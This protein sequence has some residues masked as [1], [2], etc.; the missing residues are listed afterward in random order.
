LFTHVIKSLDKLSL[1]YLHLIEPRSTMAGGTDKVKDDQPSASA[2][3]RPFFS[4][5][6]LAA[7]GYDK[8]GAEAALAGGQADAVAF[9]RFF[10]SNP[11]LPKRFETG[12]ALTPYDRATFYGGGAKGYVD[13][14]SLG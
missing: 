11:D 14:P 5:K 1:A 6:I 4:G 12:A 2:L 8:V 10:I 3:F 7:G 9:G 13:Y